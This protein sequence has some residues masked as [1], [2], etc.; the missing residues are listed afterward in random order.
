MEKILLINDLPVDILVD[1]FSKLCLRDLCS[2]ESVCKHW[3]D[4]TK[5]VWSFKK[6]LIIGKLIDNFLI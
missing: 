6:D 1:I 2:A 3:H 4:I 5:L